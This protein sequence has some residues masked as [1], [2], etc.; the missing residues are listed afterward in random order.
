MQYASGNLVAFNRCLTSKLQ[1][2]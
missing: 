1:F 2:S